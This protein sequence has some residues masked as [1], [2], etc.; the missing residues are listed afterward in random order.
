MHYAFLRGQLL[1]VQLPAC[2]AQNCSCQ[3]R[4]STDGNSRSGKNGSG[5]CEQAAAPRAAFLLPCEHKSMFPALICAGKQQQGTQGSSPGGQGPQEQCWP[6]MGVP[7][8]PRRAQPGGPGPTLAWSGLALLAS[9]LALLSLI[10]SPPMALLCPSPPL[11]SF[12]SLL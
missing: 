8:P 2:M 9:P 4:L 1:C 7:V 6:S 11:L 12:C 3:N 5:L 10:R